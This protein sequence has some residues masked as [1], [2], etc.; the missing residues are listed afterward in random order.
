MKRHEWVAVSMG[1]IMGG[2]YLAAWKHRWAYEPIRSI[3]MFL[4]FE[5][6]AIC[7]LMIYV[8]A[9]RKIETRKKKGEGE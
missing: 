7:A 6:I 1:L 3:L 9:D 4:I 8:W 5:G 2:I